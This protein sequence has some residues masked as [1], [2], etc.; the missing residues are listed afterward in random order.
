MPH[1]PPAPDDDALVERALAGSE[2]A[3]L[4]LYGRY[5]PRLMGYAYRMTG[6]RHLAED[7]F[8]STFLY[9]FQHLEHY[10]RRGKLE[11]YLFRIA[12]SALSDERL[13][14]RRARE[15][16][17][18]DPPEPA[19]SPDPELEGKVRAALM[20]LSP[21]LR[22]AAVL[23]IYEGLDYSRIAEV[24]GVGEATAR[25]RMR[26]ALE[27]LRRVLSPLDKATE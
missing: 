14:A 7:V 27:A 20:G 12:R 9:F 21:E 23:R 13:A 4:D 15:A 6:D 26:Y 25:S 22:E 17:P 16:P 11:A 18:R 24:A 19:F 2:E 8:H 10:E 5:R 3:M 1:G